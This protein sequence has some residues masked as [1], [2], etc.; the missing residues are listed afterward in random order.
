MCHCYVFLWFCGFRWSVS[1]VLCPYVWMRP[2]T[3]FRPCLDNKVSRVK[4][5]IFSFDFFFLILDVGD[6][7][8]KW[9]LVKVQSG[10]PSPGACPLSLELFFHLLTA[11]A[12]SFSPQPNQDLPQPPSTNHLACQTYKCPSFFRLSAISSQR[13]KYIVTYH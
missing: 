12:V 1:S 9:S 11:S 7:W 2:K 4:E 5:L 6:S 8:E 13:R 3:N 10:G